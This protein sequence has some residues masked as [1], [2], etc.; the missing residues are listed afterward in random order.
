MTGEGRR[1]K[2]V[3]KVAATSKPVLVAGAISESS[4]LRAVSNFMRSGLPPSTRPLR[5]SL[6]RVVTSRPRAST[7]YA[8]H[9][10]STCRSMGRKEPGSDSWWS[11]CRRANVRRGRAD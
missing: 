3:L 1:P 2:E 4:G 10:S 5:R 8:S 11:C 9:P 7:W 6:S